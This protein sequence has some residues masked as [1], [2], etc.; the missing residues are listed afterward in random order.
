MEAMS[1]E[2]AYPSNVVG[3]SQT[4]TSQQNATN[5]WQ[6]MVKSVREVDVQKV[7]D[8]KEDLDTLLVFAGLFSAVVTT[9]VV[10]SY[11]SL[12]PDNTDE[13]VFLM[14]QSFAQNYTFTDG[15]LR[16]VT[17]FPQDLVFEVPLWALRVNGLWFGSLIVSLSTASFGMLVKQWLIEYLAMEWM[18]PEDQLRTR[19]YRHPGLKDW[20]VFEIAAML[21]LLLHLSLG[22]FFLGLCFYTAAANEVVGRSTFPLVAGWAFFALL[23]LFAPLASSRCP[24]KVTLLKTTLRLGRGYLFSRMREPLRTIIRG[25]VFAAHD[26]W[27]CALSIL[28]ALANIVRRPYVT[29]M[30][31]VGELMEDYWYISVLNWPLLFALFPVV[32]IVTELPSVVVGWA[33]RT[34]EWLCSLQIPVDV[35]CEEYHLMRQNNDLHELLL[36]VDEVMIND[37]AILETMA[38]FLRQTRA[39]PMSITSFVTGCIAHRTQDLHIPDDSHGVYWLTPLDM[40]S[41]SAWNILIALV[42][43]SLLSHG[44]MTT[45]FLSIKCPD[46]ARWVANAAAVVLS[47]SARP[48]PEHIL[49]LFVNPSMVASMLHYARHNAIYPPRR[50]ALDLI[51]I[52]F[53]ARMRRDGTNSF[54]RLWDCLP[55]ID[56]PATS[57]AAHAAIVILLENVWRDDP[58]DK[59]DVS[60]TVEAILMLAFILNTSLF[61]LNPDYVPPQL[62]LELSYYQG[63]EILNVAG[64]VRLLPAKYAD[65][66]ASLSAAVRISPS[67]LSGALNFYACLLSHSMFPSEPVLWKLIRSME[68]DEGGLASLA[69]QPA[70]CDLWVFLLSCARTVGE[71]GGNGYHLQTRDF[72]KL[73]LVLALP[74][75]PRI[76]GRNDPASDW[77]V[78]VPVLTRAAE[79]GALIAQEPSAPTREG[80]LPGASP[81]LSMLQSD[82][83]RLTPATDTIVGIARRALERLPPNIRDVPTELR[84]VLQRLAGDWTGPPLAQSD[85]ASER[86]TRR[87]IRINQFLRSRRQNSCPVA[88]PEHG[89]TQ[90]ERLSPIPD[91]RSVH[92]TQFDTIPPPSA[93]ATP[94]GQLYDSPAQSQSALA[95]HGC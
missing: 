95:T 4:I 27:T 47:R 60:R 70:M 22:L 62:S 9:F 1:E 48:F 85:A 14:R 90:G 42:G 63:E 8:T 21:P 75:V 36:S 57:A 51:W 71:E 46:R 12:Q 17:P 49:P 69:L 80:A 67:V 77:A 78:L 72:I 15:V 20:K 94:A 76:F 32:W 55:R 56:E 19:C 26:A 79:E 40:L 13:I 92:S 30:D 6:T 81:A 54:P 7:A 38:D 10:D 74:N 52:A 34:V 23:T 43:E 37:G 91:S 82:A 25:I 68:S 44:S 28:N 66:S 58:T 50:R 3:T 16:P 59:D 83:S 86:G 5:I 29:Y 87:G 35:N 84:H 31:W 33:V 88:D 39:N 11:A 89:V 18:S 93:R 41:E 53:T 45:D 64:A 24:Y 65:I 61:H 73:C 2:R